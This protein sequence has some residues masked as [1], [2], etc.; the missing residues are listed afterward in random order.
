VAERV[1]L[2]ALQQRLELLRARHP[3]ANSQGGEG[4]MP[5]TQP[6]QLPA[7]HLGTLP[8]HLNRAALFAVIRHGDRVFHRQV[9]LISRSD[10]T[11]E[12]TGEQLDEADADIVMALLHAAQTAHLGTPVPVNRAELLR[13]IGRSTG[14]SDYLWFHRRMRALTEAT[15]FVQARKPGGDLRYQI[16]RETAFHIVAAFDADEATGMYAVTLDPRWVK[17]FSNHEYGRVDWAKRREIRRG[18]DMAKALQRLF[19]ASADQPQRHSVASLKG[20]TGYQG[21][22]RDFLRG[23]QRALDELVRVHVL[24]RWRIESSARGVQQIA[25]WTYRDGIAPLSG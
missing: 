23:L 24:V 13:S 14:N 4:V 3:S 19:S 6:R 7:I 21:R 11:V 8:N 20:F 10:C 15:L 12:Y 22:E 1:V 9:R 18:Q 17:L 2:P 25:A 16:G 5:A